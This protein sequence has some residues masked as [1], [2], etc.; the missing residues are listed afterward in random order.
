M[1]FA[2]KAKNWLKDTAS[3]GELVAARRIIQACLFMDLAWLLVWLGNR[4]RAD[5][6]QL[7]R[8]VP[9]LVTDVHQFS[10]LAFG[11]H[12]VLVSIFVVSLPL[13]ILMYITIGIPILYKHNRLVLRL[14]SLTHFNVL[15][16]TILAY[17]H[18]RQVT[19]NFS[20][21]PGFGAISYIVHF[22]LVLAF[23]SAA[24]P[25]KPPEGIVIACF[26]GVGILLSLPTAISAAILLIAFA[27][28]V[29][30]IAPVLRSEAQSILE[31]V[32]WAPHKRDKSTTHE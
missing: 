28:I 6:E 21:I 20:D 22:L 24:F 2:H 16:V 30:D 10:A 4:Y 25:A 9:Q 3:E 18:F 8:R 26:V 11:E 14:K 31:T 7:G 19:A 15:S 32:P 17:C 29:R 12:S 1:S 5:I 13:A 27:Y 23:F